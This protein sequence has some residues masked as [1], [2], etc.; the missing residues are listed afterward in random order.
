MTV[1]NAFDGEAANVFQGGVVNVNTGPRPI[2]PQEGPQVRPGWIG[3][4]ADLDAIGQALAQR[5]PV[6]LGGD[7]GIGKTALAALVIE[8]FRGRYPD[9]QVYVDLDAEPAS[10]ALHSLLV[11]LNVAPH[12]IPAE[13]EGRH[14]LYRSVTR[15]LPL[16][17]VADGVTRDREAALFR[18]AAVEAGYVVV[19]RFPLRDKTFLEHRL[20]PLDPKAAATYLRDACPNLAD[21]VP[22]R[23]VEEFGSGPADLSALA[24]LIS[25]RSLSHLIEVREA[26]GGGAIVNGLYSGL[27]EQAKWLFRFLETLRGREF[28]GELVG[29]FTGAADWGP[30]EYPKAFDELLDAR[31]VEP[32]RRGWFRLVRETEPRER[33]EAPLTDVFNAVRDSFIWNV[34]RA[35]HADRMVM[36]TDRLRFAPPLPAH[37]TAPEFNSGSEAMEWFR[38]RFSTLQASLRDAARHE[39]SDLAWSLVEALWAYFANTSRDREAAECYE[40]ALAVARTPEAV[41]HLS[42]LLGMCLLRLG[43]LDEADVRLG[44]AMATV[45]TARQ[46]TADPGRIRTLGELDAILTEVS[47]RLR[48]RQGRH[49]EALNLLRQ[50]CVYMEEFN[51][52]KAIGIRLRVIAEI[53]EE[54]GELDLAEST[55]NRASA[56]FAEAGD[57][58]NLNGTRLDLAMLRFNRGDADALSEVDAALLPLSK[59]DLWQTVG[60][61]H[62]RV[63]L[64]LAERGEPFR[65]RAERAVSLFEAHGSHADA[66]RV[67]QW[68]ALKESER[69]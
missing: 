28:E 52:P 39:W 43:R 30:G 59:A 10:P 17:V 65:D 54:L 48:R 67:R 16:L 29:I 49:E 12:Q 53:H 5:R 60:E 9:G 13:L 31:L 55:W 50:S 44:R 57:Q 6:A 27:S 32:V 2:G 41:A 64:R 61:T 42:A 14:A 45:E 68:L 36:A 21:G 23:L 56:Y 58:R 38:A 51:R 19:T 69:P 15:D 25:Q 37:V 40:T 18:P 1:H 47:G 22:E 20:G 3:R 8:R 24:G 26:I 35:Q 66:E 33:A 34:R 4:E 7:D 62:E 46:S 63:A 11:R